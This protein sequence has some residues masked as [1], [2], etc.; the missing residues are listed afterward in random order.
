MTLLAHLVW[1]LWSHECNVPIKC[2]VECSNESGPLN[3]IMAE[4]R[5]VNINFGHH[6]KCLL[7][8]ISRE[9]FWSFFWMGMGTMA[10]AW[11]RATYNVQGPRS[12]VQGAML[13]CWSR[14]TTFGKSA[15]LKLPLFEFALIYCHLLAS[16]D[17]ILSQPTPFGWGK[18][19]ERDSAVSYQQPILLAAGI[20]SASIQ[21]VES[22]QHTIA[23]TILATSFCLHVFWRVF[24]LLF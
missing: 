5:R 6:C 17:V 13:I 15:Q 14:N 24:K 4:T 10:L 19:L 2:S 8:F 16:K 3:Y 1:L 20:M 23:Y 12:K 22:G 18:L 21:K 7:L 9:C 11:S